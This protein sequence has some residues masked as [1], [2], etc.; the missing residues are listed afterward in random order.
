VRIAALI[1]LLL[2]QWFI[3]VFGTS[4][5]TH[6]GKN[7]DWKAAFR[8]HRTNPTPATKAALDLEREKGRPKEYLATAI[9]GLLFLANGYLIFRI[10]RGIN[11]SNTTDRR[12]N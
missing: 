8:A 3:F 5:I 12:L 4:V 9:F 6:I 7:R 1:L 11:R 2:V 10:L